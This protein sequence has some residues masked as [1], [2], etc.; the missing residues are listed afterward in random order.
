M[1]AISFDLWGTLI[2]SNPEFSKAQESLV[3]EF[4]EIENWKELKE[5]AKVYISSQELLG[6]HVDRDKILRPLL[7][8]SL[9]DYRSF[10]EYSN[11]LF[12]KNPPLLKDF[13]VVSILRDKGYRCYISSNTTF[14]YGDTLAKVVYDNFGIIK[15]NCNFSDELGVSKP[16]EQMFNFQIKPTYHIGD[17]LITD[18]ASENFG[19]EHYHINSE[20][21]FNTFLEHARI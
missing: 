8:L 3:K 7:N 4:T 2:R 10:I 16:N 11:E 21:N 5:N 6:I 9:K 13:D 15:N 20:Q 17:N 18:G 1:K 12:L 19:I 14:I